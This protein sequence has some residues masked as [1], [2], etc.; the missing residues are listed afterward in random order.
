MDK[1]FWVAFNLIKGIGAVRL[2]ALRDHFSDLE[3]A[4]QAPIDAL[5]AAGLGARLAERVIQVRS[6][7]D[8]DIHTAYPGQGDYHSYLGR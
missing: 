5:Q 1:R 8:L 7:L 2:Q 4:W 6:T 3:I